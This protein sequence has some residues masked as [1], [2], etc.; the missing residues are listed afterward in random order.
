MPPAGGSRPRLAQIAGTWYVKAVVNDKNM[1]KEIRLRKASP[2]TL[3]ALGSGDLEVR[4]TFMCVLPPPHPP[5]I[6]LLSPPLPLNG[7]RVAWGQPLRTP[8][9]TPGQGAC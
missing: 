9:P 4:F 7:P 1:P 5:T 6:V 3:T 2:L 8:L